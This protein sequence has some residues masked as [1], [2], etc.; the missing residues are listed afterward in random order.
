MM[1]Y[2]S[3]L[4]YP[5]GKSRAVERI[6]VQIPATIREYR[7]PFIGGGSVYFG[8]R[9]LF[10]QSIQYAINDLNPDLIHFWR[11]VRDDVK[12]LANE[13]EIYR[14][15]Y[16]DD[17]R[18]LYKFLCD[19]KNMRSDFDRAVRFFIMNRITFSGVMDAGGYSQQAFDKRFT[20]SSIGRLRAL[21]CGLS[22]VEITCAD[23]ETLVTRPGNGVFLF[24]DPPY[25]SA[26]ASKLYGKRGD[27]HTSFDHE[28][29]ASVMKSVP[30][31]WLITYD[32]SPYIRDL[33]AFAHIEAWEL[34]YGMGSFTGGTV[35]KGRELFIR[36]N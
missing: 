9:S 7:E 19:D 22:S 27:L 25:Y 2:K 32:D 28:R 34:Q 13:I 17:G 31:Q 5:G 29:F 18:G 11:M 12:T 35:E 10:G 23:Y 30:H 20:A 15:H 14:D 4:R 6:M 16:S 21:D 8:V 26:T 24:L 36:S 33:F 3:P 1:T